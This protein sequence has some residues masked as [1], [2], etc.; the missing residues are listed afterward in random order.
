[1]L[2]QKIARITIITVAFILHPLQRVLPGIFEQ[3]TARHIEQGAQQDWRIAAATHKRHR[4]RPA[5][6]CAAQQLQQEGLGLVVRMVRKGDKIGL[7][8][9]KDSMA[10]FAR[11]RF[12]AMLAQGRD[13]NVFYLQGYIKVRAQAGAELGPGICIPADTMMD[14]QRVKAQRMG[15]GKLVQQMQQNYRIHAAAQANRDGASSRNERQENIGNIALQA[16]PAPLI[17]RK[18]AATARLP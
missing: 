1:M 4:S 18:A 13:V 10:Q 15:R 6:A 3:F 11:C 7:L 9:L 16:I 12:D 14:M 8:P 17:K 2:A 5:H